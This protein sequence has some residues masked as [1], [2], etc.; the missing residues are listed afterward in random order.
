MSGD[1]LSDLLRA[2]R[3][4]GAVF[5]Y[6][7][8]A[9]PWVAEAPP[10]RDIIPGIMP[11]AEHMIEFHGIVQGSCW[12]AVRGESPIR[13]EA[14]DVVLFP[15]GDAH[16]LSS[17]PG[18]RAPGVDT[19]LFFSPRP[20]QLPYSLSMKE[21]EITTAR[22]DGGGQSQTT[23]VCGF[24]GLD[25]RPFNPL[26]TALPR[27]IRVAGSS[28]GPDSWVMTFLRQV[29]TE[30]NTR[31]PGGEAVLERMSEML[32]VEVLRRYVDT[33]P[34]EETGWLAGMRDPA[35]GRALSLIHERPGEPWTLERLGEEAGLSRSTLHERFVHFIGQPPMQYL[36]QWRMQVASGLLRDTDAKLVQIALDVGYESEAAFSRAFKRVA[37]VSPGA[38]R[39]GKRGTP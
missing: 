8:G 7:E 6:I 18:M 34:S 28:L 38:W 11:G 12:A 36:A 31:R 19:A 13:M 3:F 2:V 16:V 32:F 23:V 10:A 1:T 20:P 14:G 25:A 22:L 15:Q 21:A 35:V 24:L 4:R 17:A 5:Y 27:V 33:L 26:L 37:G 29:V 30:S 9:E 39:K